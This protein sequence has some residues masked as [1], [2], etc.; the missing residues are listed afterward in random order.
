MS[1]LTSRMRQARQALGTIR[2]RLT[3]WYVGLLFLILVAFSGFLYL[4]LARDLHTGVDQVLADQAQVIAANI[5][6]TDGPPTLGDTVR[7]LAA[8]SVAVLYDSTGEHVVAGV[9]ARLLTRVGDAMATPLAD[10]DESFESVIAPAGDT[11]RV[12][13]VPIVQNGRVSAILRVA[14]SERD[15][16]VALSQLLLLMLLAIPLTLFLAVVGGLFLAGRAL[17]PIDRIRRT[18]EEI[19]AEDLSRRLG[20]TG[21]ADEL[22]KLAATF[23]SMLGRLDRAF[24]RQR[25]FTA[26]ASHE[27]RT[28]LTILLTQAEVALE[29]PRSA[30]EY[31]QTLASVCDQARRMTQLLS[32]LLVLARA[33]AG[34]DVL[35]REPLS[36]RDLA[37]DVVQASQPLADARGV[38]LGW[39]GSD[40][41]PIVGDQTRVSQLLLNLIDNGLKHTPAGGRVTVSVAAD[42]GWAVLEV[43]DTGAGIAPEHLPHVFERFYRVDGSRS[44]EAGGTGLGLAI[45]DW[46]VRAHGGQLH[47]ESQLGSGST[48]RVRLPLARRQLPAFETAPEAKAMVP[49][50]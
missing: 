20:P 16:D 37:A 31:R 23:D 29:R 32:E 40:P 3:L 42:R 46:I 8:G 18:A 25:Q 5:R 9:P 6:A 38:Q 17:G 19:G 22:G 2:V 12:T 11:W 24:Q 33:D 45:C 39:V 49:S 28:P 43:T 10:S 21:N 34:E 47:V 35:T 4:R 1:R 26:D 27:L 13:T 50:A 14:R 41:A 30:P 7:Q 36:L 15:I 44:R 48:F